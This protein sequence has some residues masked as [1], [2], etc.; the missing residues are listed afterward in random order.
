VRRLTTAGQGLFY[1]AMA[2]ATVMFLL[3]RRQTGSEQQHE[4]V[5]ARLLDETA[6]RW[7]VA[8]VGAVILGV[9]LWQLWVAA[10]NGF[11]DS[12][13]TE[14]MS[15]GTRRLSWIVGA[16]GIAARA[17]IV[18]P[19]GV[20]LLLAAVSA[21]PGRARGLDAYLAQLSTTPAGRALVWSVAAGLAV[22]AG[23]TLL[24]VRYRKVDSG[25]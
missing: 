21:K 25:E 11:S 10:S 15:P 1:L 4:G 24:E 14:H 22:F 16:A 19:I 12:L 20:L 2:A 18:A 5:T 6:G 9:C 7:L 13:R 17:A 3:G 23:Y 8:G